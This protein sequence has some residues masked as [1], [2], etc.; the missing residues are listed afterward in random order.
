MHGSVFPRPSVKDPVTGRRKAVKGSTWTAAYTI[1]ENGRRHQR[2]KGGFARRKDAEAWLAD[3]LARLGKGD[4]RVLN[5]P[6]TMTLADYLTRWLESRR[7]ALKPS[8]WI[9]YQSIINAWVI[10]H[11]GVVQLCEVTPTVLT[12]LY[13]TLRDQG[14]APT[15]AERRR[16][17]I[18][19]EQPTGTPLGSRSVQCAHTLLKMALRDAV[20]EGKLQVDP[21]SLI[22]KRQRPTHRNRRQAGKYFDAA[23]AARFLEATRSDRLHPLWALLVDTGV[24]RGEACALRWDD[25]DWDGTVTIRANR[26]HAGRQVVEGTTKSDK[27]RTVH[28]DA[29]T[30]AVLRRWHKDQMAERLA[31]G[32]SYVESGYVFTNEIGEP[33]RPGSVSY[34][35]TKASRAAD[36][37]H[38]GVHG[39]RHTCATLLL[40]K[41]VPPHVV[42]E[43]L[44]HAD[45]A[46]TLGLYSH[47]MPKQASDAARLL[48][49]AIYGAGS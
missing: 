2:T 31:V 36:V 12:K 47:V 43:R 20:D 40:A 4:R 5:R 34:A 39:L 25:V 33:I 24:R 23:E 35:F 9:S 48:G 3:Q 37:R 10:P 32:P 30:V 14:G 6:S 7:P 8:T 11:V 22:P 38:I 16:A 27:V 1:T 13:A 46:I 17:T 49:D 15:P 26:V 21:T 19:G 44:G 28:L 41:G 18:W 45:I 42:Q 29:R